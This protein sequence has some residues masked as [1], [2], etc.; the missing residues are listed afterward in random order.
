MTYSVGFR[1]PSTRDLVTFFGDHVATTVTKGDA[2]Y[3]DPDL[4]R[5]ES[6]GERVGWGEASD[7]GPPNKFPLVVGAF[8][9]HGVRLVYS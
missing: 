4:E 5:Q 9:R 3:Q 1:A 8:F 7:N 2:F 6:H